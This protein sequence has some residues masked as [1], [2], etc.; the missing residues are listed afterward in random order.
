MRTKSLLLF[1][2]FRNLASQ[3]AGARSVDWNTTFPLWIY[4]RMFVR[5]SDARSCLSFAIGRTLFPPTLM[6][7]KSAIQVFMRVIPQRAQAGP[8]RMSEV[9][10][11]G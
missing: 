6:P 11:S 7:R 5:F 8:L 4:V 9:E 2:P 3:P 10:I 1:H